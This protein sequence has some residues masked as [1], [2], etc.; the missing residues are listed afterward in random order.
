M[1]EPTEKPEGAPQ[2]TAEQK[3]AYSEFTETVKLTPEEETARKRRNLVIAL[4]LVAFAV[5]IAVTTMVRMS[6]NYNAGL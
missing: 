6:S 5:L 3:P 4:G 2:T 1:T